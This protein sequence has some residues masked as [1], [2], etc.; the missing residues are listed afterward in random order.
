MS[1]TFNAH[2]NHLGR[3]ADTHKL[4]VHHLVTYYEQLV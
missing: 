3:L 1:Q 2:A 4:L